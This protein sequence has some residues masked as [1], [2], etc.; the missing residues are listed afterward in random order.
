MVLDHV[1]P[2]DSMDLLV[3]KYSIY[4][5]EVLLELHITIKVFCPLMPLQ[6]SNWHHRY[7]SVLRIG[8]SHV[9]Y[10]LIALRNGSQIMM[11]PSA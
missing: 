5:V 6:H 3:S 1:V 9:L 11:K 10:R 4:F 2:G 7:I 8:M